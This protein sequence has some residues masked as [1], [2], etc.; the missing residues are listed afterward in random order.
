MTT[1]L[2]LVV[3]LL[4][5]PLAGA[6]CETRCGAG[7]ALEG[8]AASATGSCH[9]ETPAD[10]GAR[11]AAGHSCVQHAALPAV[12][13]LKTDAGRGLV[14]LAAAAAAASPS[15]TFAPFVA[16]SPPAADASSPPVPAVAQHLPLRI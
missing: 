5:G 8:S 13:A 14:K 2:G 10:E 4:A 9:R 11:L 6:L 15:A 12:P 16:L 3:A 7:Q 1:A